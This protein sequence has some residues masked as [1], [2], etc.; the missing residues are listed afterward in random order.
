MSRRPARTRLARAGALLALAAAGLGPVAAGC[1]L[2]DGQG[3]V[4]SDHLVAKDCWNDRFDLGP[5]FFAAVPFR[6]SVNFRTFDIQARV[7]CLS[8]F[9]QF[10]PRSLNLVVFRNESSRKS[11]SRG[12]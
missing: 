3:E 2:G 8:V 11:P 4:F 10:R 7:G 9:L 5:D 6:E 12:R 1:S